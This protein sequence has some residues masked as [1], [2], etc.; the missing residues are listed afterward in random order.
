MFIDRYYLSPP[1]FEEGEKSA[2]GAMMEAL[3]TGTTVFLVYYSLL[4]W[5]GWTNLPKCNHHTSSFFV[6][7]CD[8]FMIENYYTVL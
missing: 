7:N 8:A 3:E 5:N 6:T 1:L 2:G 4:Y